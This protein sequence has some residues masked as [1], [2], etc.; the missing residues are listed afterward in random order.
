MCENNNNNVNKDKAVIVIVSC[1]KWDVTCW[2]VAVG[3]E[4]NMVPQCPGRSAVIATCNS[5]SL[6]CTS[7]YR[8]LLHV[9]AMA[10]HVGAFW[11]RSEN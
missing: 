9:R 5:Y 7:C 11:I 2:Y 6:G 1:G 8:L 3:A 10:L 4:A